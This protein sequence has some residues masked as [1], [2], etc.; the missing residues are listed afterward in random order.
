M[1]K[2]FFEIKTTEAGIEAE[3]KCIFCQEEITEQQIESGF[4]SPT[5]EWNYAK[6][7]ARFFGWEEESNP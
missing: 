3:P 4:C 2:N 6:T 7:W 1:P 5:C